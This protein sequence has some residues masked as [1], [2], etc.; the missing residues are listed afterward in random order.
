MCFW[1]SRCSYLKFQS[2]LA[3]HYYLLPGFVFFW[4]QQHSF[5]DANLKIRF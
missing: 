2:N 3:L 1:G 4:F 5:F